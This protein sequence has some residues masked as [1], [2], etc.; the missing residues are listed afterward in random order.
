M[1][2]ALGFTRHVT[3]MILV[4]Q[5]IIHLSWLAYWQFIIQVE[6]D[7]TF[8]QV[9]SFH[10]TIQL[11]NVS[12]YLYQDPKC[13]FHFL[14]CDLIIYHSVKTLQILSYANLFCAR[15]DL[16]STG[17]IYI[18]QKIASSLVQNGMVPVWC[19]AIAWSND[20][21]LSTWSAGTN[22]WSWIRIKNILT[23]R[24]N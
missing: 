17:D 16:M 18:Q 1:R 13:E 10:C 21:L 23:S 19:W 11:T 8:L 24:E 7:K 9:I 15:T 2:G 5:V 4:Y 3:K 22:F 14:P 20:G 6:F 12:G